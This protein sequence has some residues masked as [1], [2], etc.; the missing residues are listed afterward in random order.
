M[1]K[2]D[3]ELYK[4]LVDNLYDGVYFVDPERKITYWNKSAEALTGYKSSEIIGKYCWN[5]ILMH[6]DLEGRSLCHGPCP[7][8]RAMKEDRM[9]EQE[10]YLRHK[11]GHR[12]PVLVR[13]S[14]IKDAEGRVIGAVEIFSD[15]SP[16]I[17]LQQRV[18]EL[19]KLALLDA[20]TEIG[21]RRY[22]ELI[23]H[24]K[25]DEMRRYGW[26]FG[27][28]FIDIDNFKEVN[29]TY[30]H[31]TGDRV[32]RMVAKTLQNAIRSSD[33]VSRWG[34]EEFVAVIGHADKPALSRLSN[35]LRMLVGQSE[36]LVGGELIKVTISIGSTVSIMDDTVD[37]LVGRA[38]KLMY[39]AKLSGR[40]C[41]VMD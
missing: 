7:L 19:E 8:S 39:D 16:K 17:S 35:K 24:S 41:V 15:N 40:N 25:L 37:S 21:N 4:K 10:V 29:D 33:A 14:P 32:L 12:V 38:D 26:R 20:L 5:N 27:L 34:G 9:L 11:K 2:V 13:A 22:A 1:T 30:G 18:E 6:V 28:L 23:V 3:E 31:E 36:L